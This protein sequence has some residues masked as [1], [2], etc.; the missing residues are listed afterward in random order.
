MDLSTNIM[1]SR[2]DTH[3]LTTS[4]V[5]L[6]TVINRD[7]WYS[8]QATKYGRIDALASKQASVINQSHDERRVQSVSDDAMHTQL[9]FSRQLSITA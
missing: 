8:A 6:S 1:G 2:K 4:P 9:G 3:P 7:P 5:Q